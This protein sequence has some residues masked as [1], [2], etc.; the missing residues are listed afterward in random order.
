MPTKETYWSTPGCAFVGH[1][2]HIDFNT[3]FGYDRGGNQGKF[4]AGDI[5]ADSLKAICPVQIPNKANIIN[6]LVRCDS[7][8]TLTCQLRRAELDNSGSNLIGS[9]NM[10]T[11]LPVNILY[12]II[13][14]EKYKYFIIVLGM[15]VEDHIY[16]ARIKYLVER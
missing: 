6:F 14:N 4:Q 1:D 7:F 2:N 8:P 5:P 11:E 9:G 10:N 16:G 3:A 12:Q 13:D 15:S